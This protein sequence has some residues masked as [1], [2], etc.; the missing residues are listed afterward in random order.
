MAKLKDVTTKTISLKKTDGGAC[1][2]VKQTE[3]G[4][5]RVFIT[6]QLRNFS[7]YMKKDDFTYWCKRHNLKTEQAAIVLGC[8]RAT[9]FRYANGD[10]EIPVPIANQCELMDLLPL[11]KSLFVIQKRLATV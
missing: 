9:V 1:D 5:Y 3:G 4:H 10:S 2:K 7:I 8:S 11:S 6:Q